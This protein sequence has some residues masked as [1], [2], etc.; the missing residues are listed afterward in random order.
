MTPD[1]IATLK[2]LLTVVAPRVLIVLAVVVLPWVIWAWKL[3]IPRVPVAGGKPRIDAR[4][5]VI[6]EL[7]PLVHRYGDFLGATGHLIYGIPASKLETTLET[8]PEELKAALLRYVSALRDCNLL[9]EQT[10]QL[11]RTGYCELARVLPEVEGNEAV[12]AVEAVE[13]RSR[14]VKQYG[15]SGL[16]LEPEQSAIIAKGSAHLDTISAETIRLMQEFDSQFPLV[17]L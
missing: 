1:E 8:T 6:A 2:A 15:L 11:L 14:N 7:E 5:G 10:R 16:D 13:S 17:G 9:D 4:R 12:S 3:K